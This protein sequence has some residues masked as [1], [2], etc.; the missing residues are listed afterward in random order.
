ME[1]RRKKKG[2]L[3]HDVACVPKGHDLG[4]LVKELV[5]LAADVLQSQEMRKRK[6]LFCPDGDK[7]GVNAHKRPHWAVSN[8][9][10]PVLANFCEWVRSSSMT[11]L[12]GQRSDP[13][14]WHEDRSLVFLTTGIGQHFGFGGE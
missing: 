5:R 11:A 10:F 2:A 14:Q 9:A 1:P 13:A 8:A 3:S 7:M 6:I 12:V 4:R